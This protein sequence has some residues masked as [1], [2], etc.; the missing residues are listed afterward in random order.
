[1]NLDLPASWRR[2]IHPRRG[3]AA[4]PY[5]PATSP[6]PVVSPADAS[7]LDVATAVAARLGDPTARHA[8]PADVRVLADDWID[9]RG[10]G[11]AA[12]TCVQYADLCGD[13]RGGPGRYAELLLGQVRRALAA[14]PEEQFT[15]AVAALEAERP[16]SSPAARVAATFLVPTRADWLDADLDLLPPQHPRW[17]L[18][19]ACVTTPAQAAH[20]VSRLDSIDW[21]GV[22]DPTVLHTLTEALGDGILDVYGDDWA[23]ATWIGGYGVTDFLRE[24]AGALAVLPTERAFQALVDAADRKGVPAA[25]AEAAERFPERAM[26]LLEASAARPRI[27]DL[28]RLH[29]ARHPELAP[30][31]LRPAAADGDGGSV[32]VLAAPPW[33]TRGKPAKPVVLTGLTCTDE[34]EVAWRPGERERLIAG[35]SQPYSQHDYPAL[36]EGV[37]AG[38]ARDW[39]A[40]SLFLH[41][42]D[43]IARPMLT[44]Y[45]PSGRRYGGTYWPHRAAAR[46]GVDALPLLVN[47]LRVHPA[48]GELLMPYASPEIALLMADWHARL[49]E[50]RKIALAWLKAHPA[51]AARALVPA[52]LGKAGPARRQAGL[53][54]LAL[55]AAGQRETVLEAASGYGAVAEK[56]IAG[57]LDEDPLVRQLPVRIPEP[58]GW[59]DPIVLPPVRVRGGGGALPAAQIRALLT[60]LMLS[61]PGEPY[62]GLALVR[63][64][65]EPGDLAHFGLHLLRRWEAADAP[66]AGGWAL[67]AQAAI[68]DD[69][70][71]ERLAERVQRWP[72]EGAHKRAAAGLDVLAAFGTEAALRKL[73]ELSGKAKAPAVRARA[74]QNLTAAAEAAGLTSEQLTDRLVPSFDLAPDATMR[75]DYGPRR[76]VAGFDEQLRPWVAEEDGASRKDLPAPAARD[77]E[78]L[79]AEAKRRF[80]AA[81]KGVRKVA[82]EQA[83]RLERAM[84]DGRRWTADEFRTVFLEHPLL[85][86][87][88]RRL[89]WRA[90]DGPALR[91]AEDRTLADVADDEVTLPGGALLGVA[92]PVDLDVPAWSAVFA[93]YGILQPFDQLSR[94]VYRLSPDEA[95]SPRLTRYDDRRALSVALIGLER[96]GWR[97]EGR[98]GAHQS[99]MERDLPGGAVLIAHLD[100]GIILGVPEEHPQQHLADVWICPPGADPW[101]R[102]RPVPF[103]AL[104]A[105]TASEVLR[106]LSSTLA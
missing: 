34:P 58:P 96:R 73:H 23:G 85:W 22:H 76:F 61:K 1:M 74:G 106:D 103:S 46:F 70:S 15:A 83:Q 71:V 37:R 27:G 80:T 13:E 67:D 79:A 31:H 26:R 69:E 44:E 4:V 88:A 52:A 43:E 12:R 100:P 93:D 48:D 63:E 35:L 16:S 82:T 72:Y 53:A 10:L 102:D 49:K 89:V 3:G 75:L 38:T 64:A 47:V 57:L 77:D 28:L 11:F 59:A 90:D 99:R 51:Q 105:A 32:P 55:D 81:K 36:A 24:M 101:G 60:M 17:P 54:L 18:L 5:E 8:L 40:E 92:H 95:A 98:D 19:L 65:C 56:A 68:G 29:A 21:F 86:L 87:L 97:R 78:A 14:A 66:P 50:A 39:E 33:T 42:P 30:E 62:A 45:R 84:G 91:V 7:A 9:Q 94:D 20:V 2:S 41:G 25:L 6:R 104:P